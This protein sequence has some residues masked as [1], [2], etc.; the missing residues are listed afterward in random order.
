M[1]T[2]DIPW[3]MQIALRVEKTDPPTDIEA[4]EAAARA[5]VGLL[6]QA[7]R[8]RTAAQNVDADTESYD[9]SGA[10]AAAVDTSWHEAVEAWRGVAIRK[11]VRRTR[12]KRWDDAQALP[13]VTCTQ[14]RA[15]ARAFVPAPVK[16][17]ASELAKM[18]VE[19]TELPEGRSVTE[20]A[21]V[22][23]RISPLV[24]M[25]SGK[26]AAQCA[27]AAQRAW[28]AMTPDERRS[29]EEDD[30]HLRVVRDSEE[31][32]AQQPGRVS[33]IDA[34][35]TELEGQHETTRADW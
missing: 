2:R 22:T 33:I 7:E 19:G 31:S 13:G 27:H 24:E 11:I 6:V 20:N 26:S 15:Q 18:Q 17:L 4:C 32:W 16:P 9:G 30:H 34:G 14:G 10:D 23:V 8:Q 5:C 35:F 29:W 25:T 12:G 28:E 21:V 1:T 3:A